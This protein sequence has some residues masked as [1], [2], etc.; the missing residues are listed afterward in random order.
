VARSGFGRLAR[1]I[2]EDLDTHRGDLFAP[3]WRALAVYRVASSLPRAG[4]LTATVARMGRRRI[5]RRYGID[6]DPSATIGRKVTIAHQGGILIGPGVVIGDHCLIRH[7]VTI[8]GKPDDLHRPRL[9]DGVHVGVGARVLGDV[10]VGDGCRIG[11]NVV[12]V[13]DLAPECVAAP[14]RILISEAGASPSA[15]ESSS[16]KV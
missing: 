10:T 15:G 7:R 9:G 16:E 4:A 14:P 8:T 12:L 13:Q 1:L 11:P 6:L 5:R 3:G 2:I